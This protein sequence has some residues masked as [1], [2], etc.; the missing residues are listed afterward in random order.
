MNQNPQGEIFECREMTSYFAKAKL[1]AKKAWECQ[2][3]PKEGFP[4]IVSTKS[5]LRTYG[6]MKQ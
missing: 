1:F 6:M 4:E 5:W 3:K 2:T